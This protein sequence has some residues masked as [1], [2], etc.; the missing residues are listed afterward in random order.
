MNLN[1]YQAQ[2]MS[3]R[4]PTADESYVTANLPAEVGEFFGHLAKYTRDGGDE[5]AVRALCLKELGDILWTITALAE[6]L[7]SSLEEIATMNV[8]K[9]TDRSARGVLQGSGDTR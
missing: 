3:F 6:D 4:L 8:S 1:D 5:D 2:A 7:E 9:L